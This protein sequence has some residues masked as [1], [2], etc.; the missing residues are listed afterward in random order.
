MPR[1]K[2]VGKIN[3]DELNKKTVLKEK[4]PKLLWKKQKQNKKK[5]TPIK[6][7][8]KFNLFY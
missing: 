4:K 6:T 7:I 5:E 3:L 8:E 1:I 2:A